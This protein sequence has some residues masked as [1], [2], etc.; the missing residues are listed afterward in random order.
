M[1][2]RNEVEAMSIEEGLESTADIGWAVDLVYDDDGHWAFSDCGFGPVKG[3]MTPFIDKKDWR[4]NIRD[5]WI[6]F[7]RKNGLKDKLCKKVA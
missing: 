7:V 1:K 4:P 5:A 6:H 2:A 3:R